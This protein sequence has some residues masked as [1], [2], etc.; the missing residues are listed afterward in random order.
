VGSFFF[1]LPPTMVGVPTVR[2]D[3]GVGGA[4]TGICIS[5]PSV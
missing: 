2:G 3:G 1:R 4:C 5:I